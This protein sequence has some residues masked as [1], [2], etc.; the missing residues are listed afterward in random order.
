MRNNKRLQSQQ[1]PSRHFSWKSC[2]FR[3]ALGAIVAVALVPPTQAS[4]L[5]NGDFEIGDFT[6][7]TV[8]SSGNTFVAPSITAHSGSYS[9]W[10]GPLGGM[11]I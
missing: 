7:W 3:I 8:I 1:K 2:F 5:T 9:A 4:V 10:L 11:E 6:G